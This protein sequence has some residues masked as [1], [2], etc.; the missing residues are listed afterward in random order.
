M[1]AMLSRG[2][3]HH[4]AAQIAPLCEKGR[5][6]HLD[7]ATGLH[8]RVPDSCLHYYAVVSLDTYL[9]VSKILVWVRKH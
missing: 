3:I 9:A 4:A 7:C 2:L 6:V 5:F 1:A 8:P